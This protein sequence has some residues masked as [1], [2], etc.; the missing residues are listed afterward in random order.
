MSTRQNMHR[1]IMQIWSLL[2][3]LR[4][5]TGLPKMNQYEGGLDRLQGHVR[6]TSFPYGI[7]CPICRSFWEVQGVND[8]VWKCEGGHTFPM[9]RGSE[10][11]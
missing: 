2:K 6:G 3:L 8:G 10:H 5:K 11:E 4:G 1:W 7:R 9:T